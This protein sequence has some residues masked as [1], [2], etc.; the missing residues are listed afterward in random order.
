MFAIMIINYA[1]INGIN[2]SLPHTDRFRSTIN[3]VK[4]Y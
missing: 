2:T 3:D 4:R 1:P